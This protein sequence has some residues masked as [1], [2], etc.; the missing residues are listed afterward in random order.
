MRNNT[1]KNI[2][3]KY[4]VKK[5]TDEKKEIDGWFFSVIRKESWRHTDDHRQLGPEYIQYNTTTPSTVK[6]MHKQ[7]NKL[8]HANIHIQCTL[9]HIVEMTVVRIVHCVVYN[10]V[11]FVFDCWLPCFVVCPLLCEYALPYKPT[12]PHSVCCCCYFSFIRYSAVF[13]SLCRFH[14]VFLCLCVSTFFHF[15]FLSPS[16]PVPFRLLALDFLCYFYCWYVWLRQF[17]T[18]H[19]FTYDGHHQKL[20]SYVWNI[21]YTTHTQTIAR[22]QT[23]TDKY[24]QSTNCCILMLPFR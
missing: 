21:F 9:V 24:K 20:Y 10:W 15:F 17:K 2:K 22:I 11:F 13:H 19:V 23:H 7:T 1:A 4:E 8:T 6:P 5:E 14:R 12:S 16:L 3:W 18:K